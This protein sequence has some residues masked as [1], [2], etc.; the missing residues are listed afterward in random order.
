MQR[1]ALFNITAGFVII[2][3][4]ACGGAFL[5]EEVTQAFKHSTDWLES[6]DYTLM[7]SAHNHFNQFGYLMVFFGLTLPY[8]RI[9]HKYKIWQT[10]GMICGAV[11]M[12]PLLLWRAAAGTGDLERVTGYAVGLFVSLALVALSAHVAGLIAKYKQRI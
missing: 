9:P 8:S 6:W 11:G 5:G 2:L 7:K 1:V 3:I 4:A 12:G 10:V